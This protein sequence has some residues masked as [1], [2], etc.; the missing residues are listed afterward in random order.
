MKIV[1]FVVLALSVLFLQSCLEEDIP[2][3]IPMTA[4]EIENRTANY[5]SAADS[6]FFLAFDNE[7]VL[8]YSGNMP[9]TGGCMKLRN[10]YKRLF[11]FSGVDFR[12]KAVTTLDELR[13][14]RYRLSDDSSSGEGMFC[15]EGIMVSEE[16]H[17]FVSFQMERYLARICLT[18][19]TN[20]LKYPLDDVSMRFL[21]VCLVNVPETVYVDGRNDAGCDYHIRRG[22]TGNALVFSGNAVFQG[23]DCPGLTVFDCRAEDMTV[24]PGASLDIPAHFLYSFPSS[25][26]ETLKIV[27]AAEIGGSV[28]YYPVDIGFVGMNESWEMT[29]DI[30][31]LGSSDPAVAVFD[32][33]A[34]TFSTDSFNDGPNLDIVF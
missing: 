20:K 17:P 2:D 18:K 30:S 32:A 27:V 24:A 25:G 21:G 8:E 14:L 11:A 16:L 3:K 10:G 9:W 22:V 33:Q 26:D 31:R 7:G 5:A 15:E 1:S 23:I 29:L 28:Y 34:A 19:I 13:K 6:A 12:N 4:V